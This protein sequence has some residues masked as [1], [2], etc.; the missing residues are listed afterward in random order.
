MKSLDR[1]EFID[2][3]RKN[4]LKATPQ[5][6]AVHDAMMELGHASADMVVNYIKHNSDASVTVASVYNILSE[7]AERGAYERRSSSNNKMY[8][9]INA[10]SH[11]HFYDSENHCF[12]DV[13]DDEI[14]KMI[15]EKLR[16]KRFRGYS[17]DSVEIHIVGHPTKSASRNIKTK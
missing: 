10:G 6:V 4:A 8:F 11:I 16:K 15:E 1:V 3:L 13:I 17:V 12:R 5:R 14:L 7:L 2:F 9:D